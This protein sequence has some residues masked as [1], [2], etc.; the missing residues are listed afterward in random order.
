MSLQ[1]WMR[2]AG[3]LYLVMCVAALAGA[4]IRAEGPAGVLDRA[5]AGDATARF[6]ITTWITLGLL[7]GVLG[8]SLLFFSRHPEEARALAWTTVAV[9]L[10]WGVPVDI[11]KIIRGQP[12]APS[13]VWI[14]IHV[15]VAG[16]GIWALSL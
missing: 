9:E 3:L 12:P 2:I 1:V 14:L 4:P 8:A 13:I 7:L 10:A 6:L 5:R 16:T 15:I 11:F